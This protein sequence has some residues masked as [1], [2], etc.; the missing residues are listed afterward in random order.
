MEIPSQNGI[1]V[2][3]NF[4]TQLPAHQVAQQQRYPLLS[5]GGG[6]TRLQRK[7]H[8]DCTVIGTTLQVPEELVA[9]GEGAAAVF[10]AD[11]CRRWRRSTK[12]CGGRVSSVAPFL[13]SGALPAA[14]SWHG[15]S[16]AVAAAGAGRRTALQGPMMR[17][18]VPCPLPVSAL[19]RRLR[20]RR[21]VDLPPR[22][23]QCPAAKIRVDEQTAAGRA[24]A[25]LKSA[26]DGCAAART[27][28]AGHHRSGS[29][30]PTLCAGRRQRER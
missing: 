15:V 8:A 22:A 13:T 1:C 23:V 7:R 14:N 18:P 6:H 11:A 24:A 29:G 21:P 2:H 25:A 20:R 5:L 26:D 3:D 19:R 12:S 10:A 4:G 17:P 30:R 9:R 16:A 27:R 28:Q